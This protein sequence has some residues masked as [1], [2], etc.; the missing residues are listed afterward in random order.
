VAAGVA[1]VAAVSV[2]MLAWS[3]HQWEALQQDSQNCQKQLDSVMSRLQSTELALVQWQHGTVALGTVASPLDAAIDTARRHALHDHPRALNWLPAQMPSPSSRTQWQALAEQLLTLR[4]QLPLE[5][6]AQATRLQPQV[7]QAQTALRQ[8]ERTVQ[9]ELLADA[10]RQKQFDQ[11]S[12]SLVLAMTVV[13]IWLLYRSHRARQEATEQLKLREAQLSAIADSL[14]D[15]AFLMDQ[16]GRYLQIYGI[17]SPLLGRP[18]EEL[19][20]RPLRDF[21]PPDTAEVFM[22]VIRRTLESG[23]P[24]ALSYPIRVNGHLRHFDSRC[25]PVTGTDLVI[26]TVWDVSARRRAEQRLIHM[27]RLYDFLSHVNQAIVW[28][29][30]QDDLLERVCQAAINHGRFKRAWV[31]LDELGDGMFEC[32]AHA[33]LVHERPDALHFT[34]PQRRTDA[35]P[36]ELALMDG[37]AFHGT[38]LTQ[39]GRPMAWV[40][41]MLE[42]GLSACAMLPLTVNQQVCGV[43]VLVDQQLNTQDQDEKALL[44][45]VS[46]DLSFALGN[47]QKDVMREQAEDRI[48]LHAAALQSSHDGMVV[49]DRAKHLVSINP[50]FTSITGYEEED[51]LGT[52]PEFLFPDQPQELLA[53]MRRALRTEGSWQGEVWCQRKSGELFSANV[54]VSAVRDGK[55]LPNHFVAVLADITQLKQTEAR[56]AR[57]AHYDPL[58]ELPNRSMIHQRLEHALSLAARHQTLMALLFVDLDNFK[59]VNDS[60]GHEAGDILLK[61]VAERLSQRVRQEDTLGRLGGDEFV[62]VLE[63]LRH[64]QQAAHVAQ[65]VIDT[66]SAPFELGEG[67]AAEVYV[68]ASVGISLFPNDGVRAAD[69]IRQADAAMYQA[70][71]QGRNTF[72]FYT[73]SLTSQAT[74]RLQLETRLRRAVEQREFLLHYQPLMDLN[75][76]RVVGVEALV[77][78]KGPNGANTNLPSI[79]PDLF[80]PVMED[81]GMIVAL[82]EWV[83]REACRQGRAWQDKGLEFGRLAVNISPS[84]IRRGGV[85]ERVTR[86]LKQTG[87]PANRLELEITESG[88]M[89]HGENADLFLQQLHQMGVSISID[90]FGTGYSSLAY[91]KRFPVHQLKIDRSFVQDL[92]GNANDAQ[93]VGTMISLAH[94][95][96][97]RVVAEGVE[98]PDQEAFLCAK[99]CDMA[100]GYLFSRPLPATHMEKLLGSTR[101]QW[102]ELPSV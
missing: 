19:L 98:M 35:S 69:L 31:C 39:I 16:D 91:L 87:F 15:I 80:I 28:A 64:P 92:P 99:G 20:N 68:R 101:S 8:I 3:H 47:L 53:T 51:V 67:D 70:K 77:R 30:T 61:Q 14:P 55:G 84:E 46:A 97:M 33:G 12:L 5:P 88:L 59:T 24:Q 18:R 38:D 83:L 27:T 86:I 93:L 95:L 45:D 2:A 50:A 13:V 32:R 17:N 66:L 71:R 26:W 1:L 42:A 34:L 62:L 37:T 57:M 41:P 94:N 23:Q 36:M 82:G 49:L 9:A 11:V 75:T 22:G 6:A 58:T 29:R 81:T 74:D 21:F 56:L 7:A 54:S 65:A 89:E 73:E 25:A 10:Q 52:T 85:I 40:H 63:H 100:Q 79:G 96:R 48:R 78:L 44:D 90:D 60:L 43:L 102:S 4:Q 72:R 76:R